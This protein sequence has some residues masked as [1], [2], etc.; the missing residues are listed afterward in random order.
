EIV[1][2]VCRVAGGKRGVAPK[3]TGAAG[4]MDSSLLD[5]AGVPVAVFGPGG[6][7]A[8]GL[9]EWADLDVLETFATILSRVCYDF[10]AGN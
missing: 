6:E 4:W 9:V 1:T 8:H 2:T 5:Q 10:C 7:G 3:I